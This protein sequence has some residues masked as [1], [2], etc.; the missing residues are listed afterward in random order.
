M[1][2]NGAL[3]V[4]RVPTVLVPL[5]VYCDRNPGSSLDDN[6]RVGIEFLPLLELMIVL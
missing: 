6:E 3:S 4:E 5:G 1:K 2:G